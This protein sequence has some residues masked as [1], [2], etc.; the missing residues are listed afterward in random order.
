MA[1]YKRRRPKGPPRGHVFCKLYK[2]LPV[3]HGAKRKAERDA[4]RHEEVG[5]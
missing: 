2:L 1:N 3:K 4:F 5:G